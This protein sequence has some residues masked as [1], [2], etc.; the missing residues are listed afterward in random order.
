MSKQ[1][2][3]AE[4][5][6]DHIDRLIKT[7][8]DVA[9]GKISPEEANRVVREENRLTRELRNMSPRAAIQYLRSLRQEPTNE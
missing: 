1:P 8:E 6:T 7:A 3:D 4:L 2:L 9:N 5:F